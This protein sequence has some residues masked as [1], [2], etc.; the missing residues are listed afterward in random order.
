MTAKRVFISY[1]HDSEEHKSWVKELAE[2]FVEKGVDAYLDQWDL[3][4]GDDLA[5]FMETGITEADRVILVCT[6][7]YIER[8][9][10]GAGGVGYE[11]TIAT[12][13]MMS[14]PE[15]RRK[16]IPVIRNVKGDQKVPVFLG[17]TL[18]ADLSDGTD[19]EAVKLALLRTVMEVPAAKP[20]LG[21]FPFIPEQSPELEPEA[22]AS[23]DTPESIDGDP[24]LLF[25][26][27]FRLAFPGV[28]GLVWFEE[29]DVIK[30]RLELLLSRPLKASNMA[31]A[32]YWRGPS[33]LHIDRFEHIEGSHYLMDIDELN[34]TKI[35]AVNLG[36]YYRSFVYI[37]AAADE[38]TGLYAV[39]QE[40][41]DKSLEMRGYV[42]E[43]YGLVDGTLPISRAEYDDG[44]AIVDGSPV[45]VRGRVEL[46]ARY[47]SPYNMLIAPNCSPI[48]NSSFDY[49]LEA[50][51]NA[52]LTGAG[53]LEDLIEPIRRLPRRH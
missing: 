18:Y 27:R 52:M 45:D 16:F 1:S 32:W 6:D 44:A 51:L 31:I 53:S 42:D 3:E 50:R 5:S 41:F 46:R 25:D 43:E 2:F 34:I 8:A 29:T 19:Q 35:A 39:N 9:N 11:K 49:E 7:G 36:S 38:A 14:G 15:S 4:Y 48:N 21:S 20:P 30:E 26:E 22:G 24:C 23:Q 47:I 28:R 33:N 12:A 37:E 17:A 10:N 13:Q 40:W